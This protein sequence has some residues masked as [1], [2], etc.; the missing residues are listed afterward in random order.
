M[1]TAD[2]NNIE[3]YRIEELE[4]M[5]NIKSHPQ[6]KYNYCPFLLPEIEQELEKRKV[7]NSQFG[8][9][10]CLWNGCEC[11]SMSMLKTENGECSNYT[12]YD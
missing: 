1:G 6:T 2:D 3:L 7:K 12:Y 4:N 5:R 10:N 8:C 9:R 11:K